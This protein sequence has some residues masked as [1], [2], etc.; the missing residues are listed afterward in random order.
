[1][2]IT[3][4]GAAREVTGSCYFVKIGKSKILVDCGMFQGTKFAD[5]K[6]FQV[7]GFDAQS[8]D[9]VL[10]THGHLDHIGRLPKLINEKFSGTVYMTP[11]TK[12]ITEIV[13]QDTANIMEKDFKKEHR[14]KLY[15]AED[16]KKVLS[17]CRVVGYDKV[18][19]LDGFSFRFRDAG[20]ILGSSFIEVRETGGPT[21]VFS[22][23]VG[24]YDVP[25]LRETEQIEECD[26]LITESTYGDRL[27]ENVPERSKIFKNSILNTIKQKGVLLIP[28]F[29]V[30]RTQQLL[31]ELNHLV[32]NNFIPNIDVY[33][34][35][36]MAIKITE[37]FK[38]FP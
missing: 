10:I 38:K 34:D 14:P 8:I 5:A 22:G 4:Y 1:M 33:L 2:K 25:I 24:N 37:V 26:A 23:D 28:A 16:V 3:F 29:A 32:E 19:K 11:P 35:S 6:N 36:P 7:F 18:T 15:E 21:V 30:E 31:Y 9:A 17:R 12:K 27:H 13:L 20:H